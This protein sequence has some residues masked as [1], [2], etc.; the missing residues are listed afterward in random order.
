MTLIGMVAVGVAGFAKIVV[1]IFKA[2]E[3]S[4]KKTETLEQRN[5]RV[6][7][8]HV[9]NFWVKGI[10][11]KSLHGAALIEPGIQQDMQAVRYPWNIRQEATDKALPPGKSMLEIFQEIGMGRSLLILGAPGSG[12]TTELL[13]L[14][15]Q[16]IER[17][18]KDDSQPIPVVF[19]LSAWQ[20]KYSFDKWLVDQFGVFYKAPKDIAQ[21]LIKAD[22]VMLLLDGLDE[23]NK[24]QRNACIQAINLFRKEQGMI[25]LAVCCRSEEYAELDKQLEFEGAIAIQPLT[26]AQV[27]AYFAQFGKRIAGLTQLLE[28]DTILCKLTETP[29]MLSVMTLAYLDTPSSDIQITSNIDIQRKRLFDTYIARMFA[30]SGRSRLDCYPQQDVLHWLAWLAR[31]MI[32]FSQIPFLIENLQ[33][34]WKETEEQKQRQFLIQFKLYNALI[35]GLVVGPIFWLGA[36]LLVAGMLTGTLFFGV[37]GLISGLIPGL[38]LGLISGLIFGL[39]GNEINTV[40]VLSWSWKKEWKGPIVRLSVGLIFG[41]LLAVIIFL[42]SMWWIGLPI[43]LV[44]GAIGVLTWGL[45][46]SQIYETTF[47]NQGIRLSIKNALFG[48]ASSVPIFGIIGGLVSWWLGDFWFILTGGLIVGLIA[49][50]IVGLDFGGA[51]AIKHYLLRWMLARSNCLPW[52]LV[53]F[54]DHATDLV[55]LRKVG[56][57]YIFVHRLLMEHFA[58]M[59]V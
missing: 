22:Q 57:G 50:P 18:R 40:S 1:D 55:F 49:G 23:V 4:E 44:F 11:E 3:V 25:S 42:I 2:F 12:K 30:R 14:A 24:K 58:E 43:L 38:F 19:N 10:L 7:L 29:L 45:R 8:D 26:P 35:I 9:D 41:L 17:A 53:P 28:K 47:P 37:V 54:L 13:E 5:R 15:R 6:L 31:K 21:S 27:N 46:G 56:G 20:E 52:K 32:E 36:G 16:L 59:D 39:R 34:G 33:P 51:A 48:L